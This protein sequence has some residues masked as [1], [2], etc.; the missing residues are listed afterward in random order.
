MLVVALFINNFIRVTYAQGMPPDGWRGGSK[1][2]TTGS[3][4]NSPATSATFPHTL[5]IQNIM[6]RRKESRTVQQDG[7]VPSKQS[8]N[9]LKHVAMQPVM[10]IVQGLYIEG[11]TAITQCLLKELQSAT[12]IVSDLKAGRRAIPKKAGTF[13]V[14]EYT[15]E[16][17]QPPPHGLIQNVVVLSHDL[18]RPSRVA[19]AMTSD[20]RTAR[21]LTVLD[22]RSFL[23]E[24][25]SPAKLPLALRKAG[26]KDGRAHLH[27]KNE[28][29]VLAEFVESSDVIALSH[30]EAAD[31]DE[32]GMLEAMLRELNPSA[33]IIQRTGD[34]TGG[35]KLLEHITQASSERPPP[36]ERGGCWQ[37]LLAA[38]RQDA[39]EEGRFDDAGKKDR[40]EEEEEGD[41]DDESD[42]ESEEGEDEDDEGDENEDEESDE[43]EGEDDGDKEEGEGEEANEDWIA[44]VMSR[45]NFLARRP[46]H[47]ARLHKLL[48]RGRL[49]GVIRS[50]GLI[51]VATHP[52]DAIMWNQVR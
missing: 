28:C 39:S 37:T 44:P 34:G 52:E 27:D 4:S 12:L 20:T 1:I 43:D 40:A 10:C 21:L 41:D 45:F 32:L 17:P 50:R 9:D 51:W 11:K 25:E 8:R 47:P 5:L 6:K 15:T 48:K 49:D 13:E 24:W 35:G 16:T 31:T 14:R 23:D 19:A 18:A 42:D 38:R 2:L 22:V 30:T 46:F 29:E 7:R 26:K 33:T 3:C 36:A